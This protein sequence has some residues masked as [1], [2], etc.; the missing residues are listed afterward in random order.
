MGI[1]LLVQANLLRRLL[2]GQGNA[3]LTEQLQAQK[4]VQKQGEYHA[5]ALAFSP[6][7]SARFY[8]WLSQLELF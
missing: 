1:S 2:P 8:R 7:S 4:P 5:K 6:V 3:V